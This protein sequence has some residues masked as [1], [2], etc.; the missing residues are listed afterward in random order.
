MSVNNAVVDALI[1]GVTNPHIYRKI[2]EQTLP[3][4]VVTRY[5]FTVEGPDAQLVTFH[6]YVSTYQDNLL[7]Y[8][9][10]D[11]LGNELKTLNDAVIQPYFSV[12]DYREYSPD[13]SKVAIRFG[14][15]KWGF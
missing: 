15:Q 2:S 9:I 10:Y 4:E 12:R 7:S 6:I 8:R 14:R 1:K 13:Y 5:E 11:W 3:N